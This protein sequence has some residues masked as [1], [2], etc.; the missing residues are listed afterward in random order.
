[1]LQATKV[2]I[3]A[4]RDSGKLLR[5]CFGRKDGN[6][7][8]YKS[9]QEPVSLVDFE[10]NDI[11]T[12]HI[13]RAFPD[14]LILSE[15]SPGANEAL[16]SNKP[17]WVIDPLDGTMNFI[18]G[19]PLFAVAIAYVEHGVA[20]SGVI[21]DPIHDEMFVAERGKGATVN[22]KTMHV[23]NRD[24][25]K[26][27]LLY[28]GRGYRNRDLERH[29]KIIFA[30]E[31]STSYF[32]RLGTAAIMLSYVASGR[33]DALILTGNKPWD[34][35]AGAL[36]AEEAGGKISDYAGKRWTHRSEDIVVANPAIHKHIIAITSQ[37]RATKS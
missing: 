32:R 16:I 28:A 30:L 8:S 26:G 12:R 27:A 29:G 11:I 9:H 14:H 31:K 33:A 7:V 20:K 34:T 1:M 4:A 24:I 15:E 36:L 10:S 17:T 19:V 6:R 35:M 21:Y 37:I 23:S 13:N 18:S 5:V 2:A 22:G 3:A 25:V